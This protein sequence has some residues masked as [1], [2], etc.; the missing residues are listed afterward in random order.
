MNP[1][2][3]GRAIH[4]YPSIDRT[5]RLPGYTEIDN[6]GSRRASSSPSSVLHQSRKL[7]VGQKPRSSTLVWVHSHRSASRT[8][9]W[10]VAVLLPLSPPLPQTLSMF[11]AA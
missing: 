5:I 4:L 8:P 6:F 2:V 1:E 10:A 9:R 3:V 7:L 11:L